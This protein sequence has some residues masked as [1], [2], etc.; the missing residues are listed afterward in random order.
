MIG[1]YFMLYTTV[2]FLKLLSFHHVY[3]DIRS[4]V[5]RVIQAKK[6]EANG[7][8]FISLEPN[9]SEGTIM[10]VRKEDFDEAMSYPQCLTQQKFFRYMLA[11]TCCF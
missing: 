9:K 4:L 3:H 2:T 1:V 8:Q 10:G 5:K 11:P 7:L 6:D